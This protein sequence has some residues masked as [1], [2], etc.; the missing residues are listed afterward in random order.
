MRALL[1]LA[2]KSQANVKDI[3]ELGISRLALFENIAKGPIPFARESQIHDR[4]RKR[5]ERAREFQMQDRDRKRAERARKVQENVDVLDILD[6]MPVF[7]EL[8]I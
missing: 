4:D 5:A 8:A 7:S 2:V 1:M 3:T 6:D